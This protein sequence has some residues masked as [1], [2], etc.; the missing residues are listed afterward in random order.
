MNDSGSLPASALYRRCSADELPFE[1]TADLVDGRGPFGQE[2]AVEAIRFGLEIKQPGHNLFVMGPPGTGRRRFVNDVLDQIARSEQAPSDWCDGN[3]FERGEKPRAL[4]AIGRRRTPPR[5]RH[6]AVHR[7]YPGS[8]ERG[9]LP[10]TQYH[11]RSARRS[12]ASSR[13]TR[14]KC[15]TACRARRERGIRIMQPRRWSSPPSS[16]ARCSARR[17]E[18]LTPERQREIQAAV[19]ATGKLF[20]ESMQDV[21]ERLR[22]SRER[23]RELDHQVAELA[24]SRLALELTK[25]WHLIPDAR[26]WLEQLQVD[27]V[28]HYEILRRTPAAAAERPFPFE[29][30]NED[31]DESRAHRRYG[32]NVLVGHDPHGGAPIVHEE[33][34]SY[35]RLVGKIEHRARFGALLTAFH[36]IRAGALHEANGG[37]WCCAPNGCS[38]SPSLECAGDC[39]NTRCVRIVI[40]QLSVWS[41]RFA[42]TDTHPADRQD[43]LIGTRACT[44][45]R[46]SSTGIRRLAKWSR[47]STT[48]RGPRR[49]CWNSPASSRVLPAT[50]RC[51][52]QPRSR[53]PVVE[54]AS[55][56]VEDAERLSTEIRRVADLV[57]EACHWARK[58]HETV[59]A[60]VDIERAIELRTVRKGR[61]RERI[62]E[63]IE[64]DTLLIATSGQR[65]GQING[66]A[67]HAVG[68]EPFGRP[69]RITARVGP[70]NGNVLDIEREAELGGALH[71]K[72]VMILT[73]YI[74][75]H[76]ASEVPAAFLATLAFEQS[77]G[78]IDGDSASSAELYALISALAEVPLEQSFAVTGSVNQYGEIQA[79]GGVNHK[80]EGFFDICAR[81]GLTGTQG[82]LI[83]HANVKHLML[84]SRV[85]EA[86]AAGRF[87]IHAIEHVE[88][89]LEILTG[90]AAG[91]PDVDGV[92][93]EG[94]INRRVCERLLAFAE[95]RARFNRA[96][97]GAGP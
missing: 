66:L 35:T 32:V 76:Y 52:P 33:R 23:V 97:E 42:R 43:R 16:M 37:Y 24:I 50:T 69:S 59:V 51:A 74:H 19:E 1:T 9:L 72:G 30:E 12:S 17:I 83:P 10:A 36:L 96:L 28:Q 49:R 6:H 53:R 4:E 47:S 5:R 77:Y 78:G 41:A 31:A 48:A 27:L 85:V 95:T 55:R 84:R 90:L 8:R 68:D 86:V 82:V 25:R 73:G 91:V 56:T 89:G 87:H 2:R 64:R 94:S 15:S 54:D 57:R 22:A 20:Q 40:D 39:L 63:E 71:T 88:Q 13:R 3:D 67:V 44:T 79:I 29:V 46:P 80:I 14:A 58:R 92:Y 60:A 93:P 65:V 75:A 45:C 62:L 70:G 11:V 26:D 18:K 81:R 21:P 61:L 34:P 38:A 7:R